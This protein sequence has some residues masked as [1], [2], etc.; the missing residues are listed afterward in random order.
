MISKRLK[1][2]ADMVTEGYRVADIGTDHGYVPIYL[3]KE[4]KVPY[5]YAM[6]IN[7]GPI[8]SAI[9]NVENE[10]FED[11]IEVIQS[12][13]M[14]KLRD[15]MAQSVVIAGMGGELIVEILK[16]SPVINTIEELILSPHRDN[17]IV[18]KYL[19]SINWKISEEKML[20]DGGKYY[21]I[22]KAVPGVEQ[23]Y[24]SIEYEY[25]KLLIE[26]KNN[27]LKQYIDKEYDKYNTIFSKMENSLDKSKEKVSSVIKKLEQVKSLF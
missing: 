18:R 7:E 12:N 9:A 25:G 24:S 26:E 21:T 5:A 3:I 2:V 27:I 16:N 1:T 10:G 22:I 11:K 8:R 15:G 13:G 6:D 20:I 14:E 4:N 17:D 19:H 23:P